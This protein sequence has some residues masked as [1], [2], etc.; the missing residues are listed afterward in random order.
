MTK[1]VIRS[2]ERN[3]L[4]NLDSRYS[5]CALTE[6]WTSKEQGGQDSERP[7]ENCPL[8]DRDDLLFVLSCDHL[9][10]PQIL[11]VPI[12][13]TRDRMD[14]AENGFQEQWNYQIS[15]VQPA[16]LL[17]SCRALSKAT[18]QVAIDISEMAHPP[19][20]GRCDCYSCLASLRQSL[21]QSQ[22]LD[23]RCTPRP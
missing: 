17:N 21:E 6:H 13:C 14:R 16:N 20:C 18:A 4:S 2:N 7:Y 8:S 22:G 12:L 9:Q 23:G 10:L 11:V 3:L 15:T 5:C 1:L 19:R